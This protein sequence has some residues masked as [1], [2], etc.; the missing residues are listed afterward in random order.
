M[1]NNENFQKLIAQEIFLKYCHNSNLLQRHKQQTL[2]IITVWNDRPQ[3]QQCQNDQI[4]VSCKKRSLFV[5]KMQ[6]AILLSLVQK[7][8]R[9]VSDQEGAE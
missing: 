7:I 9:L 5:K 1:A 6:T 3:R 8:E 2:L 4:K